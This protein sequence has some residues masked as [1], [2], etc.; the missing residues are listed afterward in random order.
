M[1]YK[2]NDK[3]Y[4]KPFS[5]KIVEVE[6]TKNDDD[7]DIQPTNKIVF[8]TPQIKNEMVEVTNEEAYKSASKSS[9]KSISSNI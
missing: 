7:F 6:I 9:K 5:N 1:L 4:V 2:Y 3:I 8:L